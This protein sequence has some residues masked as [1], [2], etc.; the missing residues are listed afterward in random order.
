MHSPWAL[1]DKMLR[2]MVCVPRK[3]TENAETHM[4][5]WAR[6]LR[7]CRTKHQLLH[8]D[9]A[10]FWCGRA[11]RMTVT[12][13]RE[14]KSIVHAQKHGV[15]AETEAGSGFT[16]PR[17]SLHGQEVAVAQCVGTEWPNVAQDRT[18]W[19]SKIDEMTWWKM[20]DLLCIDLEFRCQRLYVKQQHV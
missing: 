15:A 19:R 12:D 11:A 7:N 6:L 20:A 16:M 13:P 5:R 9:K 8:G 4:I 18:V 10:Y 3:H 2:G 17:S 1:Q 14:T